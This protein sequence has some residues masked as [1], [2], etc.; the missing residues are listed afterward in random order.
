MIKKIRKGN[1]HMREGK[2]VTVRSHPWA[3]ASKQTNTDAEQN[4]VKAQ[5][6]QLEEMTKL[7][8]NPK[9][10]IKNRFDIGEK[11]KDK[12]KFLDTELGEIRF[13]P[14]L[15]SG[16]DTRK[17]FYTKEE[18]EKVVLESAERYAFLTAYIAAEQNLTVQE[19]LDMED[20][21]TRKMLHPSDVLDAVD[22]LFEPDAAQQVIYALDKSE[23]EDRGIV[24]DASRGY[25]RY[26]S[27]NYEEL[28]EGD[29][30]TREVNLQNAQDVFSGFDPE[31]ESSRGLYSM[32]SK[33]LWKGYP[34]PNSEEQLKN[35]L[36]DEFL[37]KFKNENR[38]SVK[39]FVERLPSGLIVNIDDRQSVEVVNLLRSSF[40]LYQETEWVRQIRRVV[41]E[42]GKRCVIST[43]SVRCKDQ[44]NP[45]EF[46]DLFG[47]AT[48]FSVPLDPSVETKTPKFK[49]SR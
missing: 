34:F 42:E 49:T 11:L 22:R 35:V 36:P 5:R 28:F 3:P 20:F 33:S 25:A 31:A 40:E 12:A 16:F 7:P 10:K 45:A 46:A 2:A 39:P 27:D 41:Y 29:R 9:R 32:K 24:M 18:G 19:L 47:R 6:I 37:D 44:H 4:C 43:L 21:S 38:A 1:T 48:N 30:Y 17:P 23:N 8:N 15:V 13:T 14:E 26:L